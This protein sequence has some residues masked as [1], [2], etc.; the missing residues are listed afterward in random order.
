MSNDSEFVLGPTAP[1]RKEDILFGSAKDWQTN[2]C[3]A[4]WHNAPGYYASG[5]RV[6]GF[7]LADHVCANGFDQDVLIYPIVYLYRHHTELVLKDIIK[8]ASS[9]LDRGLSN[10]DQRA[11]GRHKLADL[12]N[13]ARP[14]LQPVCETANHRPFP[15]DDIDGIESYIAQLDHH[16]PDGQRFRYA[17]TRPAKR[18]SATG[19]GGPNLS[20]DPDLKVVNIRQF[21]EAIEK[22]ADYLEGISSWFDDLWQ[23]KAEMERE[24]YGQ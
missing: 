5:F 9:L 7:R 20:L 17:T 24:A 23:W 2:A 1:P 12:W 18:G 4:H 16:D 11:L 6:A 15:A 3:T 14:L 21:A 10:E 8:V 22:L 19:G 13:I